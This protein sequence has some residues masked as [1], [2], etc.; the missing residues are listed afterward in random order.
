MVVGEKNKRGKYK[1]KERVAADI[2]VQYKRIIK[3]TEDNSE[4]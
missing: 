3:L 1:K 4:N 2:N